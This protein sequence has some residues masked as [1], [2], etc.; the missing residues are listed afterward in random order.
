MSVTFSGS[1]TGPVQW[2]MGKGGDGFYARI[3]PVGTGT[4]LRFWQGN[5]SGHLHRCISQLHRLRRG[6]S[7]RTGGWTG[8]TQSFILPYDLFHGGSARRRRL[9][10]SR[11]RRPAAAI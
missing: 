1:P 8:D 5:N 10:A 11:R 3:D 4:S 6:W 9:R 2:Q 7:D